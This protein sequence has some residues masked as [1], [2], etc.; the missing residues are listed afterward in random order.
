MN[1]AVPLSAVPP[2]PSAH[3]TGRP[4]SSASGSPRDGRLRPVGAGPGSP[5]GR[6]QTGPARL[7][8]LSS[9][10][11]T[12]ALAVA[13]EPAPHRHL[14]LDP[15]LLARV[16]NAQLSVQPPRRAE[17]VIRPDRPWE[18][19]MISF[20]LTVREEE[21]KLRMWYICRDKEN[22]PNLAYAES[23]DGIAWTKPNLGI[24]DYA[25]SR[26]NNLVGLGNLEGVVFQDPN[27]TGTERYVYVS[28]GKG[29]GSNAPTGLYRFTSPDG[30]RW[31][32]DPQPII[33]AGS[34][35]QNVTFWDERLGAYVL[36]IRG[37]TKWRKVNRIV[38]PSLKSPF[39]VVPARAGS[40]Y[41]DEE[42]PSVFAADERD[43]ARTDV[44]NMAAQPYVLDPSWYVA[45][46]A[47]LRRAGFTAAPGYQGKHIGTVEVQFAGSRDG[48]VWQRYDRAS[49][50][51]PGLA[52]PDKKNMCFM[53]TGLVVRG[54]EIWQYGT[55]F[56]SEH[57]DV[58]ARQRKT[59]GVIVRY[60]QRVDGFVALVT[61][62]ELGSALTVPVR[63]AGPQLR[64]NLDPGALGELRV[65]LRDRAGHEI[66]GFT[67]AA[68]TPVQT[69]STGATVGWAGQ[70][71]LQ[72]LVGREVQLEFRATRT[73]LYSFRFE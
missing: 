23:R 56:E 13:G 61:G 12:A 45:F 30:L 37:W 46:P 64:L 41:F 25:G 58:A 48:V 66:P 57:G 6:L 70:T 19:L 71:G 2:A 32:R 52:S 1:H 51:S 34:D 3:P 26:E 53:G 16:E 43:P 21:G 5:V 60:V 50:A 35:T 55:E 54:D 18:Q 22:R 9:L 63:V 42:V 17:T 33:R 7:I 65:G 44:Y 59:D 47:F 8:W 28:T 14:F 40:H 20:F 36:Y 10:A 15:S 67:A 72:S 38:L 24:A 73:K 11:L 68:C 31:Q 69:N 29:G 62:N 27:G 39:P 49:Y 4:V